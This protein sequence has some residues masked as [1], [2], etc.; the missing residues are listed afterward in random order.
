MKN[1][2][3]LKHFFIIGG[4]TF[5]NLVLGVLTTPI[6]TRLVDPIQYGQ[7][8]IFTMYSGIAVMV[9]CLGLDQALVRYYY[10]AK[11]L[12]R[13]KALLYNCIQ[14]PIIVSLLCSFFVII[15][16]KTGIMKF[17]FNS[18]IMILLCLYTIIQIIYRFSLMIVRLEYK[19]KLYSLLN[20]ILKF[21]YIGIAIPLLILIKNDS[22]LILVISTVISAFI[23][24]VISIFAQAEI[25]N[26]FD[27]EKLVCD[28]NRKE[29]IKY[30]FPYIFSM[31]ITTFFQAIDKISLNH[32]CSY[33][34]VGVYSSAMSLVHIFSIVQTTFNTLWAPMAM[35]QYV[36]NK[37]DKKFFQLGNQ[38]I[39]VVM[40]F[41]GISLILVK[42]IFAIL[43]GEKYR[44]AAYI[45]PFLI[46]N[47]IMFTISETTVNGLVFLKKSKLQVVV[48][49]GACIT[50]IIGNLILVPYLGCKG[51]AIST[52]ISYIVFFSLRTILSNKYFYVDFKLIKFYLMTIL[53]S[54]YALYN[55]FITFNYLSIIVYIFCLIFLIVLYKDTVRFCIK[56][57]LG[58]LKKYKNRELVKNERE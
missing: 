25:W 30:A 28:V 50:N 7:L 20:I 41:I 15:L 33:Y 56:Y 16:S 53:I 5:F 47:P 37:E 12:K 40:F 29:L 51:A 19:S 42:D 6:I 27:S 8:S 18:F 21:I 31:G 57:I 4:G 17:E 54:I 58:L 24:M 22:L 23:C 44:E 39:T 26:F 55:T 2:N 38:I 34:D 49:V 3:F 9:L 13:K 35:E 14:F 1:N 32:F 46:F 45:L 10:E 43:L 36:K 11:D 52:G 48:A